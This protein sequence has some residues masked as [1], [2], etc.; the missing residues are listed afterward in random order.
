MRSGGVWVQGRRGLA[1]LLCGALAV[2]ACS[3][4]ES[5]RSHVVSRTSASGDD[6]SAPAAGE[7]AAPQVDAGSA[8]SLDQAE[9]MA[10]P[11][12][13][14]S[15]A[16]AEFADGPRSAPATGP[17]TALLRDVR[18]ISHSS[19]ERV[20]FEIV[21]AAH[22]EYRVRWVEAPVMADGSGEAVEVAGSAHLEV[23]LSPASGVDLAT[24]D[25]AYAGPDRVAVDDG[26]E[27]IT[28]LVRTGDFEGV[29]TWV[30]GA[31]DEAPFRVLR[32]Q[33]PTRLVVDVA[34]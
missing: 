11:T 17:G 8:A 18:V 25:L 31:T 20:V 16:T 29:L 1:A 13:T 2:T 22:P 32:L 12:T 28:D 15:T 26:A 21:G 24:G 5:A 7:A 23:V 34:T 19:Y 4:A 3:E 14:S 10:A 6:P 30:V 33:E 9:T 27:S